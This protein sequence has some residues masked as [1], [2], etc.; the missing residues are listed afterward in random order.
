MAGY[1]LFSLKPSGKLRT[2]EMV[3]FCPFLLRKLTFFI[4]NLLAPAGVR[5]ATEEILGAI[6]FTVLP[7]LSNLLPKSTDLCILQRRRC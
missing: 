2:A 1:F 6:S 3:M 7:E 5:L 4:E